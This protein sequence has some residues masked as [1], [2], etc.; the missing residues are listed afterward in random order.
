MKATARERIEQ[1]ALKLFADKGFKATTIRDIC[2]KSGVS[3]ALIHY[4]YKNK[5]GLYE[6][7]LDRVIGD[8]FARYPLEDYLQPGMSAEQRLKQIIRLLLHRLIGADGLSRDRSRVRLMA[9]ELT[10]P[11]PAF[12]LLFQR[13]I[14][15]MILTMVDVV[16]EF[17]G[18]MEPSELIRIATS[19]AGQCL[20]P[21]IA[22]EVMNR[23][24]FSLGQDR[25]QIERHAEHI[26]QFSLHGLYG[27]S[28]LKQEEA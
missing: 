27:L 20:Y 6:A 14:Q 24:G 10:S 23:S 5:N 18:P 2:S 11:S 28:G 19:V 3:V 17:V 16:R 22:H 25:E 8:A 4:H 15:P 9:R 12:E 21:F 26:Y 7:L 13:H 1:T